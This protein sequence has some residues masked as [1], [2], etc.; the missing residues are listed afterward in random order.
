[1]LVPESR[2]PQVGRFD[3][4][5]SVLSLGVV[6]PAI[7]GMGEIAAN[8]LDVARCVARGR[9]GRRHRVH[10]SCG[11]RAAPRRWST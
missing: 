10:S 6:L 5:G 8:G 3:L 9:R 1:V 2:A 11:R 7:Y 4:I